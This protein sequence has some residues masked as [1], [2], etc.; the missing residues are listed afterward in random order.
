MSEGRAAV[1]RDTLRLWLGLGYLGAVCL[2]WSPFALLLHP[3]LPTRRGRRIGRL[4]VMAGFRSYTRFLAATGACR[5]DLEALDGLRGQGPLILAPNHPGLLDA[6]MV[7]SRLPDV[8]CILKSELMDNVF[9]GAGARLARYIR[10]EPLRRMVVEATGALAGGS[11]LLL[12]PEGTRTTRWP[13]N[14]LGRSIGM[15]AR[16]ARAPVQAIIIETDSPYLCKGWPLFRRPPMPLHYRVRLGRRFD[17]PDD[18]DAFM[19]E[20]E[21]HFTEELARAR[22]PRRAAEPAAA[23]RPGS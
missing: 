23:A 19:R 16:R 5:F 9:L 4:A 3:L 17:P 22:L 10:N 15:I 11:Q 13:F 2:L 18:A 21:A 8:A 6:V 20:L 12:F 1:L 7:I 14:P